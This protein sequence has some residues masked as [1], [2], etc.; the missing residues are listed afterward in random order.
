MQGVSAIVVAVA[1]RPMKGGGEDVYKPSP[2]TRS[3][4][5]SS[6]REAIG[7]EWTQK[8]TRTAY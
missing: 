6:A 4:F 3:S 2:F 8:K 7:R 1:N 5:L